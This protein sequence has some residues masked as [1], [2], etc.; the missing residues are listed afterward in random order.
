M[1]KMMLLLL[2]VLVFG[3]ARGPQQNAHTPMVRHTADHEENLRFT[4]DNSIRQQEVADKNSYKQ[5]LE[6][7]YPWR[8]YVYDRDGNLSWIYK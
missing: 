1:K 2:P 6:E 7:R 3:C 4:I 5:Q 8:M